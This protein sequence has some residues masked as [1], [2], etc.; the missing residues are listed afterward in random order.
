MSDGTIYC[1]GN[2]LYG[3][4]G[5]GT[6]TDVYIKTLISMVP[7]NGKKPIKVACG[8]YHTIVLMDDDSIYGCGYNSNGQLGLDDKDK[9]DTLTLIDKIDGK[10]PI[11]VSCGTYHTIVLMSDWS[12]YIC[13]YNDYGQ[14]GLGDYDNRY[15]LTEI[16]KPIGMI[17][18]ILLQGHMYENNPISDI[19]FPAG[20]P[21]NC[22]QGII[23]IDKINTEIHTIRGN[24]IIEV[25]K[26][27]TQ[28]DYLVCI[29]KDAFK[30]NVPSQRTI[31]TQS[32]E[33][34]Y[35][36]CMIRSNDL[37]DKV[38]NVYKVKYS[39]EILYNILLENHG[40]IKVN[41]LICETLEPNIYI[42]KMLLD[43]KEKNIYQKQYFIR[44][45]NLYVTTLKIIAKFNY[46]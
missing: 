25:T 28:D 5:V 7:I 26:T 41:N 18:P 32:H 31:M 12:I 3:Q 29:D 6:T 23:A 16:I 24:K 14:L 27:V 22:D 4:F 20:T 38:E 17:T 45:F 37:L 43:L 44:N 33:V 8:D 10:T 21:V 34:F 11:Q 9:R 39:G 2:N 36:G 13:G 1:C 42:T 40:F 35:N 15:I 46:E 19:C 30:L